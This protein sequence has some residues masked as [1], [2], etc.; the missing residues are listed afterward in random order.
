MLHNSDY[1]IW[2][3]VGLQVEVISNMNASLLPPLQGKFPR[4][5]C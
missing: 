1:E 3:E 5:R 4:I 2:L